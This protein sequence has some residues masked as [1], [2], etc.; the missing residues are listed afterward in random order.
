MDTLNFCF[1]PSKDSL[2]Y[3]QLAVGLKIALEDDPEA[4]SCINLQNITEEKLQSWIP[5]Y[6]IPNISER[7]NRLKEVGYVLEKNFKSDFSNLIKAAN[8]SAVDLINLILANFP[9]FRDQSVYKGR[10]VH[11]YK[12]VQIFIGD[13]WGELNV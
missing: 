6:E 5:K 7:V 1:W 2:E 13:L 10:L 12:R 9:G 4:F 3:E 8:H 11:F